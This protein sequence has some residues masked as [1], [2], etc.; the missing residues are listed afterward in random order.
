MRSF[1]YLV[2]GYNQGLAGGMAQNRAIIARPK[3]QA[4]IFWK[5]KILF[6]ARKQAGF[7]EVEKFSSHT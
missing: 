3:E 4:G 5:F 6:Y 2:G 7:A 1:H